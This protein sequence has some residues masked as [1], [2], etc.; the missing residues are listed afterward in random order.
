M[1]RIKVRNKKPEYESVC[2]TEKSNK[3]AYD[4]NIMM[5]TTGWTYAQLKKVRDTVKRKS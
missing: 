4:D 5:H 2:F 1:K 3:N